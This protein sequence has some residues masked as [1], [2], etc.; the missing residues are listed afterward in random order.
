V[1]ERDEVRGRLRSYILTELLN[2]P[3]YPLK[4]DEPLITGGLMDSFSLAQI[5]V[6]IETAFGVN[7][8]DTELTVANMD[9]L[10]QMVSRVYGSRTSA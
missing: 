2:N 6:F 1:I 10:E 9:T 7:L 8:P 4:D 5:A 3:A